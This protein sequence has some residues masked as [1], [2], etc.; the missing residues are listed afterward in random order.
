VAIKSAVAINMQRQL[1][2]M[3]QGTH[4]QRLKSNLVSGES[5]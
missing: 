1:L 4:T 5:R 2:Q 3:Q